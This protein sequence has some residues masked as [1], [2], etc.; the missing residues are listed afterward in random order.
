MGYL[1]PVIHSISHLICKKYKIKKISPKFNYK[2]TITV[3]KKAKK[4]D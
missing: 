1:I 3:Y 4:T 2:Y